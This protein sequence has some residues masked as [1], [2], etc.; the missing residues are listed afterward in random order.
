MM[1]ERKVRP[2]MQPVSLRVSV[3]HP[4][5]DR[6]TFPSS[7][8]QALDAALAL[9]AEGTIPVPLK[10]RS[11]VPYLAWTELRDRGTTD[12]TRDAVSGKELNRLFG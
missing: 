2:Q 1:F 8:P 7:P 11:K 5:P 12:Y 10:P 9:L 6:A 4:T 3:D